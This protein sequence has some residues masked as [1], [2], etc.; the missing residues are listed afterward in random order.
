[1]KKRMLSLFSAVCF[2]LCAA[3][4]MGTQTLSSST[5]SADPAQTGSGAAAWVSA[6]EWPVNE[7]TQGVPVPPGE[8]Q[9]ML[10]DEN[11]GFCAV[12]LDGVSGEEAESWREELTEAGFRRL[13]GVEEEVK[14][15]VASG[16]VSI[17]EVY[18]DGSVFLSVSHTGERMVVYCAPAE[19]HS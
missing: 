4:G 19:Q 6:K 15:T 3:C 9:E 5:E 14:G 16:V 18:S 17:G 2:L 10:L 13:A 7:Y 1:M 11:S 8:A 12:S